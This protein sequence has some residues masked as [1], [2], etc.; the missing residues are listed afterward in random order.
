LNVSA[1]LKSLHGG[2]NDLEAFER[3]HKKL[4]LVLLILLWKAFKNFDM[5]TFNFDVGVEGPVIF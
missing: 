1:R 3:Q 4:E 5:N 2:I